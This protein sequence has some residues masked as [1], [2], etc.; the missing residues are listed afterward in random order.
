MEPAKV[1]R[2]GVA[3]SSK[4]LGGSGRGA[5]LGR[6]VAGD[7]AM[8]SSRDMVVANGEFTGRK[9]AAMATI[10]GYFQRWRGRWR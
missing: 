1:A 9:A 7:E 5:V 4:D 10:A 6:G 3:E 8:T 2:V